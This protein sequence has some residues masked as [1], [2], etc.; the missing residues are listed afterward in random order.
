MTRSEIV[1]WATAIYEDLE[2]GRVRQWLDENPGRLAAGYLPVYAPR[3]VIHAAGALPFKSF[4]V[5]R[6]A[7]TRWPRSET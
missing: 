1:D 5:K 3:E 7:G 2:F 6:Y 4:G